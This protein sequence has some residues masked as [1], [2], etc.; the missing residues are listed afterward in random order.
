[1]RRNRIAV[2]EAAVAAEVEDK[3]RRVLVDFPSL[4][5]RLHLV[6]QV[7]HHGALPVR[8]IEDHVQKAARHCL[9][10]NFL[11]R[12]I[13]LQI[14]QAVACNRLYQIGQRLAR[15]VLMAHDR[16]DTDELH[17]TH[18]FLAL[19]LGVV[20][21]GVGVWLITTD[22]T[23][24]AVPTR[25][26]GGRM[27]NGLLVG[28]LLALVAA[29]AWAS[30]TVMVRPALREMDPLVAS[31]VRMPFATLILLLV[32]TRMRRFDNRRLELKR[33]TVVWLVIAGLATAV[34]AE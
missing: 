14:A 19:M 5:E 7:P 11:P 26:S 23:S 17:L 21:I 31:T 8:P 24:N 3:L 2:R 28:V 32:A 25:G 30:S 10:R 22:K 34:S 1:M 9:G 6:Q 29:V 18:E 33:G 16:V 4:R 20:V 12:K 15:W 27:N 13:L